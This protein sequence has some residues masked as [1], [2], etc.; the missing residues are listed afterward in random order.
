MKELEYPFVPEELIKQKK[1][2]KRKLLE[3]AGTALIEKRI[4]ILG[5]QT[6][7]D[8]KLMLE[9]FLLNYGIRPTFYESEYNQYYEDGMFPNPELEAFRPDLIYVCTCI[10]NIAVFPTLSDTRGSRSRKRRKRWSADSV[11]YGIIWRT[12]I[13]VPSFRTTL[14]FRSSVCW[15]IR[16]PATIMAG[17]IL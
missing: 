1:S 7:Q 12:P 3:N 8:I 9:L 14:S 11:A 10:R 13:T 5:G 16:T 17:S 4:A 6:T 15:G 2:L